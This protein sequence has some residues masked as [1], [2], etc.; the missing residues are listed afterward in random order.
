MQLFII[1]VII[2]VAKDY[3]KNYYLFQVL[4]FHIRKV[5]SYLI[6]FKI[7][8]LFLFSVISIQFY[9]FYHILTSIIIN[10][11]ILMVHIYPSA[12]I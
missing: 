7:F 12:H 10:L 3:I 6:I 11:Y 1:R 5:I 9:Y 8:D 4:L 2:Y